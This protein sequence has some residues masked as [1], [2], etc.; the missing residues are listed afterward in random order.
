M[1]R[2]SQPSFLSDALHT[3]LH[4][5]AFCPWP[6]AAIPYVAAQNEG[7]VRLNISKKVESRPHFLRQAPELFF[8]LCC[9]LLL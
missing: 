7:V 9:N 8:T 1:P 5:S 6:H 4:S 3:V 2:Q